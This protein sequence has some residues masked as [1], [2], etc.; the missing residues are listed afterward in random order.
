MCISLL[1]LCIDTFLHDLFC[2]VSKYLTKVLHQIFENIFDGVFDPI[3]WI[4]I[5][6]GKIYDL[7]HDIHSVY[8]RY[9][10]FTFGNMS[11]RT[12]HSLDAFIRCIPS[13]LCSTKA[14]LKE[15]FKVSTQSNKLAHIADLLR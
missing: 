10:M 2:R 7:K 1:F 4:L 12:L 15:S 9:P 11:Q 14:V 13:S 5:S 3:F 6:Y 8:M